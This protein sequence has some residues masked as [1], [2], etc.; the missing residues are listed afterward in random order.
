MMTPYEVIRTSP[1][2][3]VIN[4][5][6]LY[7]EEWLKAKFDLGPMDIFPIIRPGGPIPLA[8]RNR[9]NDDFLSL[10]GAIMS[11]LGTFRNIK[12]VLLIGYQSC[13]YYKSIS[14]FS[15][16]IGQERKDREK[17]DLLK[18][19]DFIEKL[20]EGTMVHIEIEPWYG[21]ISTESDYKLVFTKVHKK[22]E[23]QKEIKE[24]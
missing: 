5:G 19:V 16:L 8:H 15:S 24:I 22:P 17:E 12:K 14:H 1:T 4:D 7:L 21:N 6:R 3:L 2:T 13:E 10:N 23:I 9:K 20:V 18:G 11:S